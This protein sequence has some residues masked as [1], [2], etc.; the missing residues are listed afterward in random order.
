MAE[1]HSGFWIKTITAHHIFRLPVRRGKRAGI[2]AELNRLGPVLLANVQSR[3]GGVDEIGEK[4]FSPHL[5]TD[6][7]HHQ[8]HGSSC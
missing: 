8:H 6:W 1:I 5:Y 7:L 2:R 4:E 3:E